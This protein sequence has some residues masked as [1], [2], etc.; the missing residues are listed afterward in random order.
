MTFEVLLSWDAERDIEDIAL[1]VARN[2]AVEKAER[3]V[4]ALE[5][6]CLGLSEF[7]ERG[8]VPK[9]LESLGMTEFREAHYKPYRVVYRIMGRQVIVYCVLDG[10]RDMQSLLQRRLLR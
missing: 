6:T 7:P 10:R 8:N 2:D 4:A 5:E 1:Y 3:L 9:E